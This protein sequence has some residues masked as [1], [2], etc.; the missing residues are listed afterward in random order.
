VLSDLLEREFGILTRSGVHCAPLAH[1]TFG[2]AEL[3]GMTRL[4]V[5]PFVTAR[6]IAEACE[7][8]G[9]LCRRYARAG[10]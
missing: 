5:G 1:R 8:L 10:V 9:V 4:S 7:A 3:G 6:D 2:T